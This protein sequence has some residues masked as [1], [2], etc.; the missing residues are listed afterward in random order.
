M[1]Q[2]ILRNQPVELSNGMFQNPYSMLPPFKTKKE[3]IIN[4]YNTENGI[5]DTQEHIVIKQYTLDEFMETQN[6]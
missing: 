4:I 5:F 3:C 1:N 2:I 6:E